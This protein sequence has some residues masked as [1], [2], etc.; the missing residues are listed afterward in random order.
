MTLKSAIGNGYIDGN[1]LVAPNK[2]GSTGSG[3]DNGVMF[4]S[5]F[6]QLLD[7]NDEISNTIFGIDAALT[8][9]LPTPG[10]L[11]RQPNNQSGQEGPDDYVALAAAC[12]TLN[13]IYKFI[14]IPKRNRLAND[15][16]RYGLTHFG[17]FNN[18]KPGTLTKSAFLWRQP[19]LIGAFIAAADKPSWLS[20]AAYFIIGQPFYFCA[21]VSVAVSCRKTPL[22]D[23]DARR[24]AWHL[25][26][27][28]YDSSWM[29]RW[30]AKGWYQ[31]LYADY[32]RGMLDVA[33]GYYEH[34]HPFTVYW[35][36]RIKIE[37]VIP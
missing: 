2:T 22:H 7:N 34:E 21:A 17:F 3:S 5:E 27:A 24:L 28:V 6:L 16:L 33:V 11:Q 30:A 23:T 10:L 4:T 13:R 37:G 8:R 20:K 32:P 12:V 25:I 18:E 9:C 35:K 15:V 31:R 1:G 26:Q 36:E 14:K 29:M 19:Q